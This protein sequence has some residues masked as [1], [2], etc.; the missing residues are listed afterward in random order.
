MFDIDRTL[1]CF[2]VNNID[3]ITASAHE[4]YHAVIKIAPHRIKALDGFVGRIPPAC[5]Y[6][7]CNIFVKI[8]T[9]FAVCGL[10]S[11]HMCCDERFDTIIFRAEFRLTQTYLYISSVLIFENY[12]IPSLAEHCISDRLIL[13]ISQE[14]VDIVQ[15]VQ[16]C[17]DK[18]DP[19]QIFTYILGVK[20]SLRGKFRDP[21]IDNIDT[22]MKCHADTYI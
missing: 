16:I 20:P 3:R 21:V 1:A 22:L 6:Y 18:I 2:A 13:F 17:V 8:G 10:E 9:R 5:L 4:V 12:L 15:I 14:I 19:D 11:V 7:T